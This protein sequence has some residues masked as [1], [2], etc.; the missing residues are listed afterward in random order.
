M[1]IFLRL[2]YDKDKQSTLQNAVRKGGDRVFDV[3]P[4]IF[5]QIPGAPFA[6]WVSQSIRQVFK[7]FHVFESPNRTAKQGL[8]TADDFRFVR[9]WWE[10]R[11]DDKR[12]YGFAKGGSFSRFYSDIPVVVNW[13][14]DGRE[15]NAFKYSV[16]RN[17]EYYFCPGLSWP[18]RG[19]NFSSQVVPKNCVFSVGGKMAFA[20][21]NELE[22]WLAIFN[23]SSF[24]YLIRLFAGK[25][26][27]VQYQNGL[28]GSIPVPNICDNDGKQLSDLARKGWSI[29]RKLASTE[30]TSHAF[31]LPTALRP[32]LNDYNSQEIK[33][34][35]EHI[36]AQID[37]IAFNLYVF[38][39]L[40]R[41]TVFNGETSSESEAI[42][43]D[44]IDEE[45]TEDSFFEVDTTT[46][47][48]SWSVGVVF[49]RFDFQWATGEHDLPVEPDPF[50]HLPAISP[51]MRSDGI[52]SFHSNVGILLDDPGNKNDLT[53][54]VEELLEHISFPFSI[55]IRHWLRN[56]F[57]PF[58][59]QLYSKS[60]RK[61]PIY[62]PLSTASGSYTLWLYYPILTNQTL[63]TAIN[64]FI[65]GP[66]G[67]LKQTSDE[68]ISLRNI[69]S[70]RT[71]EDEKQFESL[72]AYELELIEL[73]DTLL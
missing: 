51:G 37:D 46:G 11:K 71:S 29:K 26:G 49:G 58:H 14:Y 47:L 39:A 67:K 44:G 9:T 63:Y 66:N 27:G 55:N 17:P 4:G 61:A 36:Q 15:L 31:L 72:Q 5:L 41:L 3:D 12:W 42:S 40:D 20:P 60:K 6:Y 54:L 24:D 25:V 10:V 28:I 38:S 53:H 69:G 13:A 68:I 1:T 65:D 2:L 50:D 70:A 16:I 8:A 52:K 21:S 22:M 7:K 57:F 43:P 30:E 56:D 64:D 35:L 45:M 34:E 23:S 59:L 32:R 18:L 19:I 48:L 33:I 73:R 62:W